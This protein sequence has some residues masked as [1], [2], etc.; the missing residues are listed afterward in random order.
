MSDGVALSVVVNAN[1]DE[2]RAKMKDADAIVICV[3]TPLTEAREPD[4][5]D[6]P[7][8]DPRWAVLSELEL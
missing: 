7:P 1:L 8:T 4:T 6:G 3:P 5:A 2:L